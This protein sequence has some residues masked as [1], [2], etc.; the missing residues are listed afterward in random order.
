[1]ERLLSNA[2]LDL[3]LLLSLLCAPQVSARQN[4]SPTQSGHGK[5]YLH[6]VVTPKSGPPVSGLQ[7]EDFTVL[8]NRVPQTI[9]TFRAVREREAPIEVVLVVDDVNTGFANLAFERSEIDKFL[10]TDGGQLAHPMA[11]AFLTDDGIKVQDEFSSDGN[12]LITKLDKSGLGLHSIRRSGGID[13]DVERLQISMKALFGLGT[14]EAA[15]PGRKIII[16]VSPGWPLPSDM[17]GAT[18]EQQIFRNIVNLSTLLREGQITLYSVGARNWGDYLK[19]VSKPGQAQMG[20]LELQV[21]ATQSGGLTTSGNDIAG[22][23]KQCLADTQAY[24]EISFAPPLDQKQD[25]YHHLEVHVAKPGLTARTRQGYYSQPRRAGK[26]TAES[27][28]PGRVEDETLSLDPGAESVTPEALSQQ[29]YY[30]N[31]HPYVDLPTAQLVERIPELKNLQPAPDDQDLPVILQKLGRSVDDFVREM[32]DLIAHEDVTQEKL[33]AKGNIT[34]KEHSQDNYLILRHGHALA[35]S[36][37]YRMDEKGNRLGAIGLEKGYVVT[38]GFALSC[39]PFS[40]VA[41]P[42]SRFRYLGEGKMDS[43]ETYVLGFAQ[44]PGD[45]TFFTAM[46]GTGRIDVEMLSQGILWVDK[47]SFQ[48]IRMRS[49]LLAPRNEIRLDQLTTEVG[50]A[51]VQLQDVP[52]PLWLPKD[53]DVSMEIDK[54]K[55]RNM[56]HYTDYRRYRVSVKIGSPQ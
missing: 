54:H 55:F 39:I 28:K 49:D 50:F 18:Q 46:Q 44:Q 13:S 35:A 36:S 20:N 6:V 14:R 11:L 4:N 16:W 32:G 24:Y 45:A 9:L 29:V 31:A 19:E 52:N 17:L 8:D 33:N 22:L 2:R 48:I 23:I 51:E 3:L 25:E 27:E 37:E 56:H 10:R 38:A 47:S 42:Q 5:I 26:L 12:E 43:R 30:A 53:V 41:Q 21:I 34:A 15:R 7:Q 40:T 1:V